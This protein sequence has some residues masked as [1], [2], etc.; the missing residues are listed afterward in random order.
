MLEGSSL[1]HIKNIEESHKKLCDITAVFLSVRLQS[2][3]HHVLFG[4]DF[5][6]LGKVAEEQSRQEDI[7]SMQI[8]D[9]ILIDGP[10]AVIEPT[11]LG[12]GLHIGRML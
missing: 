3:S 10:D 7:E 1:S 5:G 9:S 8:F 6:I 2:G 4:E 12:A 11:H